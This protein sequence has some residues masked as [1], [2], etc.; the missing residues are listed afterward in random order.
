LTRSH[1]SWTGVASALSPAAGKAAGGRS[2][3]TATSLRLANLVASRVRHRHAGSCQREEMTPEEARRFRDS[4]PANPCSSRRPLLRL[5]RG[6]EIKG[7]T[8]RSVIRPAL[9]GL[10]SA[11][12]AVAIVTGGPGSLDPTF[13][14]GGKVF[15]SFGWP[16]QSLT[17]V[18]LQADGKIVAVGL[19]TVRG[20]RPSAS[21]CGTR[22]TARYK[23]HV[24]RWRS[25][26]GGT[27]GT[28]LVPLCVCT[29][30]SSLAIFAHASA[31]QRSSACPCS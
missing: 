1:R 16:F 15:T 30:P 29:W 3:R 13:G 6:A 7:R 21:S 17:G 18:A 28:L 26:I 12:P 24:H 20:A 10:W 22:A 8:V 19:G 5:F 25:S 27:R 4:G 23:P 14:E 31:A 2:G 9:I 11:A